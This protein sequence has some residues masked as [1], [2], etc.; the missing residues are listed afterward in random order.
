MGGFEARSRLGEAREVM[1]LP[2]TSF[3]LVYTQ[4]KPATGQDSALGTL[5]TAP[6]RVNFHE[7]VENNATWDIDVEILLDRQYVGFKFT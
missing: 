7:G 5:N 6:F 2:T 3:I 4:S 1:P